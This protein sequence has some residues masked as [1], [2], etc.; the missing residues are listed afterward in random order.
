MK[1]VSKI[2][3]NMKDKNKTIILITHDLELIADCADYIIHIENGKILS[4]YFLNDD[5]KERLLQYFTK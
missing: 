1:E 3:R 4:H 2:L 5:E